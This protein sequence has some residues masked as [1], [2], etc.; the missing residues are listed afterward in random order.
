M[1]ASANKACASVFRPVWIE[2][3]GVSDYKSIFLSLVQI[4]RSYGQNIG[5]DFGFLY[6][7]ENWKTGLIYIMIIMLLIAFSFALVLQKYFYR[8]Y[9]FYENKLV[10]TTDENEDNISI[11]S[12][13]N[14]DNNSTSSKKSKRKTLFVDSK[15]LALKSQKYNC[16]KLLKD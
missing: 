14:L 2:Q 15:K 13:N 16:I 6:F 5:F 7:K 4:M 8:K 10:E 12:K 1:F 11:I 3:F 9:R